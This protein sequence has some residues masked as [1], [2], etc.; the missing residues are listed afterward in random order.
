[1]RKR[2]PLLLTVDVEAVA[3]RLQSCVRFSRSLGIQL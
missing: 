3:N 1:M 2:P